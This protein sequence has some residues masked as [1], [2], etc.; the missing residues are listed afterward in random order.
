MPTKLPAGGESEQPALFSLERDREVARPYTA[1]MLAELVAVPV[2]AIRR[3]TR[4]GHLLPSSQEKRLFYYGFQEVS[5]ARTLAAL[6]GAGRSLSEIDRLADRLASAY[7]QID[8]PLVEL[9]IVVDEGALLLRSGDELTEPGGQKRFDFDLPTDL[10][11]D[12]SGVLVLPEVDEV[13]SVDDARSIALE[14]RDQGATEQAI[15]A[16]RLVLTIGPAEAEDHF[17]LAELLY[18]EGDPTGFARS[19][20]DSSPN[21]C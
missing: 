9:P 21:Y 17:A 18:E 7:P 4:R 16:W 5:V 20:L 11:E 3:W 8:R 14:L 2:S 15:E 12:H 13:D 6:V 19:D 1:A 10:E